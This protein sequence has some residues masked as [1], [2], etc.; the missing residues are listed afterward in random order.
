MQIYDN[1][2]I[3]NNIFNLAK[4]AFR[5]DSYEYKNTQLALDPLNVI[6]PPHLVYIKWCYSIGKRCK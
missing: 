6:I 2:N 4:L 3:P 1:M 5:M